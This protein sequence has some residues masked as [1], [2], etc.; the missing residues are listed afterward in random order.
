MGAAQSAAYASHHGVRMLR[1][2]GAGLR[3]RCL[4]KREYEEPRGFVLT[5]VY[6]VPEKLLGMYPPDVYSLKHA[7]EDLED[8]REG[9][10]LRHYRRVVRFDRVV[11]ARDLG[12]DALARKARVYA[13]T[14]FHGYE[15]RDFRGGRV[16]EV[17]PYSVKD[18]QVDIAYYQK[19]GRPYYTV[20]KET[21]TV[22][23][24]KRGS[25]RDWR[26]KGFENG[27]TYDVHDPRAERQR[28]RQLGVAKLRFDPKKYPL[29]RLG[30][31][32]VRMVPCAEAPSMCKPGDRAFPYLDAPGK[33]NALAFAKNA[34]RRE[35][36]AR[37]AHQKRMAELKRR[38]EGVTGEAAK[39]LRAK[40][41]KARAE[42][43]A[44]RFKR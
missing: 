10:E 29:Q 6:G 20:I 11:K 17:L 42:F 41:E 33:S 21:S 37:V 24:P 15:K 36:E 18:A 28:V 8:C 19:H 39:K 1:A 38:L 7:L 44:K 14:R 25:V 4:A 5:R 16:L 3:R 12:E 31:Q 23:D 40:R 9:R 2:P 13:L 32:W 30:M 22:L 43:R 34:K 26:H 27:Y 35:K